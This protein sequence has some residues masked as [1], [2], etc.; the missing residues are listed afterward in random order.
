MSG[1]E[2]RYDSAGNESELPLSLEFITELCQSFDQ[3]VLALNK[4]KG[5]V[6]ASEIHNAYNRVVKVLQRKHR[7]GANPRKSDINHCYVEYVNRD[8]LEPNGLFDTITTN[9]GSRGGSGVLEVTT[10]LSG[11]KNSCKYN[12]HFCPNERKEYGGKHD[13]SRSYLSN[14]GVFKAGLREDFDPYRLMIHRLIELETLGHVVDK[15]EWIIIG[16][17]FHSYPEDYLDNYMLQGWRA[18]NTF[19]YFSRRFQGRYSEGIHKWVQSGGLHRSLTDIP[20]WEHIMSEISS[21]YPHRSLDLYQ[22]DNETAR[23]AR[24]V[25][26]SIET[27]PDQI[28]I[29][30]LAKMREYGCTRVQLGI[31]HLDPKIL[32]INGRDHGDS[33]KAI[34]QCLDAGFKIDLH[35]MID[36]PGATPESDLKFLTRVFHGDTHQADYCKLYYCLNLPFTTIRKWYN[37]DHDPDMSKE[38]RDTIHTMMTDRSFTYQDLLEFSQGRFVWRPY[39]ETDPD[40]FR[41]LSEQAMMMIPPW[42]RCV[43]V[44]RDFCEDRVSKPGQ[45]LVET[46]TEDQT[47]GFVSGTISTNE[48]QLI[49]QRL[50]KQNLRPFEIRSREIG[51]NIIPNIYDGN[52]KLV[53]A[54]YKNAGGWEYYIS[55]EYV[56]STGAIVEW[57]DLYN[58][59]TIGHV[60]LRVP[61]RRRG[62]GAMLADVKGPTGSRP[63]IIRELHVYGRL[64]GVADIKAQQYSGGQGQGFGKL[65]MHAAECQAI[66]EGCTWLS[67]ISGVGVRGFYR[68]LGYELSPTNK[69]MVKAPTFQSQCPFRV[70]EA[71]SLL[72]GPTAGSCISYQSVTLIPAASDIDIA[73]AVAIAIAIAMVVMWVF[74]I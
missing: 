69:Y 28:S 40:A 44:Q 60:R 4:S 12:C 55:L 64:K 35:Y 2:I 8:Q 38:E 18:L 16:G 31:Q 46:T 21:E 72:E 63:G 7:L 20:E 10:G 59:L 23:C 22:H 56:R 26:L 36:L 3:A 33:R 5:I 9:L 48:N 49:L 37:R 65:L 52:L 1:I 41:A 54:S 62:T 14:E 45:S 67:V 13:I 73:V 71:S 66:D 58:S 30:T 68:K 43:R 74:A 24:C 32:Q 25:G 29:R 47:L 39:S 50:Q 53:T 6:P 70:S 57:T 11:L 42:T 51:N 34:Q 61:L 15:I 19:H 17:T 27:R